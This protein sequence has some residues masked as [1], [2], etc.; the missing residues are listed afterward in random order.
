MFNNKEAV[1]ASL[2]RG[3][4]SA[5]LPFNVINNKQFRQALSDIANFGNGY[6]P[7]SEYCMRTS[8]LTEEVSRIEAELK[9]SVCQSELNCCH[10]GE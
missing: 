4:Y 9:N 5:G 3:F 2:A 10:S 8:L 1:D 6:T 7:P